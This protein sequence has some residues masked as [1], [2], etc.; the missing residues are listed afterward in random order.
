VQGDGARSTIL[1][2]SMGDDQGQPGEKTEQGSQHH[3][4]PATT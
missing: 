1:P 3:D 2:G 4:D